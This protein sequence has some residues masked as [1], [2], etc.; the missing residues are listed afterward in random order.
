[1]L[2]SSAE[3]DLLLENLAASGIRQS[4]ADKTI[5]ERKKDYNKALK[6]FYTQMKKKKK[7]RVIKYKRKQRY[8]H[9]NI[10]LGRD[11]PRSTIT[12]FSSSRVFFG[13]MPVKDIVE[14]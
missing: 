5:N 12:D 9:E 2:L 3:L 4:D 14:F 1:M 10:N 7:K 13:K 11:S 8:Q 6:K